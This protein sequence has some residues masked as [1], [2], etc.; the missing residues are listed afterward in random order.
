MNL[1][2]LFADTARS[3]GDHPLIVTSTETCSFAGFASQIERL[4]E[5]LR[6][7]GIMQGACVALHYPNSAEYIRLTYAVWAAGACVV[8]IPVELSS[9]EKI[10]I[11]H[12]IAIDAVLSDPAGISDLQPICS[13]EPETITHNVRLA[14]AKKLR[15]RPAGFE[16]LNPAFVRFSSGTTGNAKGVVL[17][18]ETIYERIQAANEG[19]KLGPSDR[20]VWLLSMAYHFAVSIVAYMT[21]GVTILLAPNAFGISIIRTAVQHAATILYAAPN[22][23]ALMAYDTGDAMLPHVRLAIATTAA[24]PGRVADAFYRRFQI[25][26]AETYGIIE[27]GLPCINLSGSLEKQGSVGRPLPAYRLRLEESGTDSRSGEILISGPGLVDGY[28]EPWQTRSQI[29]EARSGWF[30]T[31]DLGEL[32]QEG[33]LYIRGRLKEVISVA[34]MKFFPQEVESVLQSHPAIREACVFRYPDKR[35][36]DVPHALLV[37][38][39]EFPASA[40]VIERELRALCLRELAPHKAPV[41]LA[42]VDRLPRTASGKLVRDHSKLATTAVVNQGMVSA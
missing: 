35:L 20:V 1:Y 28:Y 4:T 29:L 8:P 9:R 10:D 37:R 18:H 41:V 16:A 23:Y 3:L 2:S 7:Q 14:L 11:F 34:G 21:Y 13:Q 12:R 36:G 5:T 32:D 17:S 40:E 38:R 6:D 30:A 15:P 42:F 33:F 27:A 22:H 39:A 25:P 24:L 19:L 31:G 26:L